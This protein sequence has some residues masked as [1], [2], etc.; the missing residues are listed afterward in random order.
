MTTQIQPT[1]PLAI[2]SQRALNRAARSEANR[3]INAVVCKIHELRALALGYVQ[4]HRKGCR[5]AFCGLL[6]RQY[7]ADP[8]INCDEPEDVLNEMYYIA[9]TACRL[10]S[11]LENFTTDV[12]EDQVAT[13]AG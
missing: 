1:S 3:T 9:E 10:A 5:C 12:P 13:E 6:R 11:Y 4:A 8:R 7:A 2:T